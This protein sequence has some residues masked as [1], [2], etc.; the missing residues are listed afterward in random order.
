[1]VKTPK[2]PKNEREEWTAEIVELLG[3]TDI[4]GI[5][6]VRSKAREMVL[7]YPI[8]KKKAP[9]L[10]LAT[11]TRRADMAIAVLDSAISALIKEN[12]NEV[13]S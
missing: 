6:V 4:R 7:E 10:E 3:K 5:A 12:R 11:G 13:P 9:V 2:K 1:M 8:A